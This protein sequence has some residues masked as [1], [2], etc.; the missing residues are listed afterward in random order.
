MFRIGEFF[1]GL[2]KAFRTFSD[3][4]YTIFEKLGVTIKKVPQPPVLAS[5]IPVS[6]GDNVYALVKDGKELLEALKKKLKSLLKS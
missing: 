1:E 2:S 5:G 4:V 6:V 3:E